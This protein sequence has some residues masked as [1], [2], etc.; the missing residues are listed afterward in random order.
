MSFPSQV[1]SCRCRPTTAA[2]DQRVVSKKDHSNDD[3]DNNDANDNT[4][5]DC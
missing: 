2:V 5:W 1:I 4:D 3:N